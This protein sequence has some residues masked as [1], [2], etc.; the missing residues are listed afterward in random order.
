MADTIRGRR[1]NSTHVNAIHR[2]PVLPAIAPSQFVLQT[3]HLHLLYVREFGVS[4]INEAQRLQ[5]ANE[6]L[7]FAAY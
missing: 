7:S 4:N 1:S 3:L 6:I 2:I 5:D